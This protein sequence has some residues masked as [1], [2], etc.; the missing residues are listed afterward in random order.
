MQLSIHL[1]LTPEE[2][3]SLDISYIFQHSTCQ[4]SANDLVS[5]RHSSGTSI[6]NWEVKYKSSWLSWSI[7]PAPAMSSKFCW[8][9]TLR[10][11]HGSQDKLRH[12]KGFA[13]PLKEVKRHLLLIQTSN[14]CLV[15]FGMMVYLGSEDFMSQDSSSQS[16]EWLACFRF[17]RWCT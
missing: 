9:M 2:L 13:L 7:M 8:I 11:I 16:S 10:V 1:T 12:W 6:W 3:V 14:S 5:W 4:M 15:Q 17:T